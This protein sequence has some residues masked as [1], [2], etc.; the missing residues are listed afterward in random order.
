MTKSETEEI[1]EDELGDCEFSAIL[2]IDGQ[3][4]SNTISKYLSRGKEMIM[5]KYFRYIS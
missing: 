2:N 1:E 3:V 4:G 5:L